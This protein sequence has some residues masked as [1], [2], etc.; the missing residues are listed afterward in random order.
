MIQVSEDQLLALV[1]TY[2]LP[3]ARVM[4]LFTVAPVLSQRS[5]PARARVAL[6][7]LITIVA[8]PT[9]NNPVTSLDSGLIALIIHET[10]FGLTIGFMA[11]LVF[12][13]FEVAGETIGLQMGL[14][15]AGFFDPQSGAS[16]PVARLLNL[17]AL[18]SFVLLNGP[19]LLLAAVIA[20]FA[21][22]PIGTDWT[23]MLIQSPLHVGS[24]MFALA[25]AV[26]LPFIILLLFVNLSLGIM[27]RV[28]P[29]FSVF[30]V[31]FP[32]TIGSGLVLLTFSVPL[33]DGAINQAIQLMM[34][35]ITY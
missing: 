10:V 8:A 22:I 15:F 25:L 17:I 26:A 33:L 24:E 7:L 12:S 28:A 1:L 30:S 16:N 20:S 11:R 29:Q 27:S 23:H 4:G 14:S 31:G 34:R 5:M 13:A 2:L 21:A 3:L 6:A 18:T 35:A 32:L 19:G 9:I